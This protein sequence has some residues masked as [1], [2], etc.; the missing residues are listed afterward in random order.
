MARSVMIGLCNQPV[1]TFSKLTVETLEQ[2]V[3]IEHI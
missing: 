3:N 1:I 2:V